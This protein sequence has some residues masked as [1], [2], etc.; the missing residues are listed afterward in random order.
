MGAEYLFMEKF[1][2][3]M[4]IHDKLHERGFSAGVGIRQ[5]VQ[6]SPCGWTMPTNP[7]D[8]WNRGPPSSFPCRE[9]LIEGFTLLLI[10]DADFPAVH[11]LWTRHLV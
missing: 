3:R 9:L 5:H 8:L 10:P 1:M 6:G 11:S 7:S 2:L 4:G